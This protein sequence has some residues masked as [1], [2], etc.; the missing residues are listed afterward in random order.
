[1]KLHRHLKNL[2]KRPVRMDNLDQILEV[3]KNTAMDFINE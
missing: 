2:L 3:T 1:M